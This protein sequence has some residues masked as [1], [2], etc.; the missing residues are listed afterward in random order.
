MVL[1]PKRVRLP[2]LGQAPSTGRLVPR[3]LPR[4]AGSHVRVVLLRLRGA[5]V[6]AG[7]VPPATAPPEAAATIR[8]EDVPDDDQLKAAGWLTFLEPNLSFAVGS[9]AGEQVELLVGFSH[10]AAGATIDAYRTTRSQITIETTTQQ[11]HDAA[12]SLRDQLV[13]YPAR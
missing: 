12:G 4:S 3:T 11:V 10:E 13:T 6:A 5:S 8:I 1:T 2:N 9:R 7:A